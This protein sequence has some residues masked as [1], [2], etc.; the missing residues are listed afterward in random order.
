MSEGSFTNAIIDFLAKTNSPEGPQAPPTEQPSH[1]HPQRPP[2]PTLAVEPQPEHAAEP[3]PPSPQPS[4]SNKK[5]KKQHENLIRI[6]Y[7]DNEVMVAADNAIPSTI[8]NHFG[9]KL[10]E[11]KFTR[12]ENVFN[13]DSEEDEFVPN[14]V[15]GKKY[16]ILKKKIPK[17][18]PPIPAPRPTP[19]PGNED[20]T[21]VVNGQK[22]PISSGAVRKTT[23][24]DKFDL[25]PKQQDIWLIEEHNGKIQQNSNQY[26]LNPGTTYY[27]RLSEQQPLKKEIKEVVAD[28]NQKFSMAFA[29]MPPFMATIVRV[30]YALSFIG[31]SITF[32]AASSEKSDDKKQ[33]LH[34]SEK[35]S[36]AAYQ[37]AYRYNNI[38]DVIQKF[39]KKRSSYKNL[40]LNFMPNNFPA[41]QI[42]DE[43][44]DFEDDYKTKQFFDVVNDIVKLL[45]QAHAELEGLLE[46]VINKM[47]VDHPTIESVKIALKIETNQEMR[48]FEQL[49]KHTKD[50]TNIKESCN[51]ICE[52]DLKIL[53]KRGDLYSVSM[54]RNILSHVFELFEK[55]KSEIE[56]KN[57]LEDIVN[58]LDFCAKIS[59][60]NLLQWIFTRNLWK[61][62][63]EEFR[64]PDTVKTT[65]S[66]ENKR[67]VAT[68][69]CYVLNVWNA[70]YRGEPLTTDLNK[71]S[72]NV[73]ECWKKLKE[74]I[75]NAQYALEICYDEQNSGNF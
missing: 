4:I 66:Y 18:L 42:Q 60:C 41:N 52:E 12:G 57:V 56:E 24:I 55:V 2:P 49:K 75:T 59:H 1:E 3:K 68:K 11:I 29:F 61:H 69:I 34:C 6:V 39:S 40:L 15:V 48:I 23:I 8:A 10:K 44:E 47:K 7:K 54:N 35:L 73:Q 38:L 19:K 16:T 37:I 26:V 70:V 20:C 74:E 50:S 51:E 21:I 30:F 53:P 14:L 32:P 28:S 72:E 45:E 27:A 5:P 25:G 58:L 64:S 65:K 62:V 46:M 9:L 17:P 22:H 36:T 71:G 33:K 67:I 63:E 43:N 31:D 13:V